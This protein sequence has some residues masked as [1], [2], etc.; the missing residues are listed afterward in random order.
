V[1]YGYQRGE[2]EGT[3]GIP[4][5]TPVRDA[6]APTHPTFTDTGNTGRKILLQLRAI[7]CAKRQI[8]RQLRRTNAGVTAAKRVP[9]VR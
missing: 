3:S 9:K 4:A 7:R 6:Y 2:A 5:G 8:L 1:D